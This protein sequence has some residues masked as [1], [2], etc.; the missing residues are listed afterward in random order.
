[1]RTCASFALL[2]FKMDRIEER[3]V[4]LVHVIWKAGYKESKPL[5]MQTSD[6]FRKRLKVVQVCVTKA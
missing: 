1:M 5:T 2:G 3:V 6:D 4:L